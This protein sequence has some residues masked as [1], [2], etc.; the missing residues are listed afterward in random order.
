MERE[1]NVFIDA[2][3]RRMNMH[4]RY[5]AAESLLG[6]LAAEKI[7]NAAPTV[8]WLGETNEC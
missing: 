2:D 3:A 8:R 1:G 4:E 5:V 6:R 7:R